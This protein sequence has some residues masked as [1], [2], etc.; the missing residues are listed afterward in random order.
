MKLQTY[1]D[2]A[3]A[4]KA[5]SLQ[6]GLGQLADIAKNEQGISLQEALFKLMSPDYAEKFNYSSL[7]EQAQK[8]AK[9]KKG[10]KAGK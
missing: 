5:K 1:N 2:A 4:A 6:E 7:F 10:T 9:S 3:K 8:A